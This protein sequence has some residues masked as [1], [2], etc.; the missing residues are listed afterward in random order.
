MVSSQ[1]Q[2]NYLVKEEEE[3][4]RF[5]PFKIILFEMQ[6]H[7]DGI[8]LLVLLIMRVAHNRKRRFSL[9]FGIIIH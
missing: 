2:Y 8:W 5:A 7:I 9:S 4:K 3:I 6:I 1:I